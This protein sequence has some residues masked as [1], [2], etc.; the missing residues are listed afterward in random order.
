MPTPRPVT[1]VAISRIRTVR[2]QRGITAAGLA[3]GMTKAGY[4][5][6]RTWITGAEIGRRQE[7]SVDWLVAAAEVLGVPPASL[8]GKPSCGQCYDSPPPGFAC[9]TCGVTAPRQEPQPET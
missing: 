7:I 4:R 6:E 1:H 9:T 3:E 8:L 5:V 2:K